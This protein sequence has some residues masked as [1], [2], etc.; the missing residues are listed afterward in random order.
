MSDET[1]SKTVQKEVDGDQRERSKTLNEVYTSK[2]W[3]WISDK[4]N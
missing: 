3:H 2:T 4:D 1:T